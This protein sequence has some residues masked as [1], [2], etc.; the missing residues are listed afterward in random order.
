MEL[1]SR[2]YLEKISLNRSKISLRT[3]LC[4]SIAPVLSLIKQTFAY[5]IQQKYLN[6]K[7]GS[8][9]DGELSSTKLVPKS[10][11]NATVI[12]CS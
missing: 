9:T 1:S 11:C 6:I 7:F 5:L 10:S 8:F 3:S 2:K 12:S 4:K